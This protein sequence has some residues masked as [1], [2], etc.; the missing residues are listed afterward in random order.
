MATYVPLE[1]RLPLSSRTNHETVPLGSE[2]RKLKINSPPFRRL[3]YT[4]SKVFYECICSCGEKTT[5]RADRLTITKS[6]GCAARRNGPRTCKVCGKTELEIKFPKSSGSLY[7]V[8]HDCLRNREYRKKAR[9]KW[10]IAVEDNPKRFFA[11]AILRIPIEKR[12]ITADELTKLWKKQNGRC[13]ITNVKMVHQRKKIRS[14]S[15]DRID[16]SKGYRLKNVQL[17]CYGANLAK[18]VYSNN[19]AKEFFLEVATSL[20]ETKLP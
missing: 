2:F 17:V 6:C 4:N 9:K 13:A 11:Y 5:I 8:V 7:C 1:K 18:N 14:A 3:G 10:L 20:D 15:V 19:E 16:S 12:H